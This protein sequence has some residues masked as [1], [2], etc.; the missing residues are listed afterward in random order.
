MVLVF[1]QLY[2]TLVD[3]FFSLEIPPFLKGRLYFEQ[4]GVPFSFV[5]NGVFSGILDTS[6]SLLR[7]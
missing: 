7:T 6:P 1:G 3:L 4:T 2:L 5:G